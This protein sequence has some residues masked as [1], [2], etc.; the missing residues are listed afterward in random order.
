MKAYIIDTGIRI[1]HTEFGG[2]ATSGF[3]AVDGGP[4]D[5]CNGHGTHVAGT[6]GGT[7]YG[8]AKQ[9][10][11]IAVRVLDCSGSG[12]TSGVISG[13]NWVTANHPAGQPAVANMSLG[14]GASSRS[15]PPC[16]T[17]SPTA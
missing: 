16:R 1:S 8:V 15:T 4:A 3:D 12:A 10:S 5:D 2:R 9:V 11:L 14:G 7:T 17:R 6:V 13:I